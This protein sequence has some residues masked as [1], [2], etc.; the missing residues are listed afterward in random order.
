ML[1]VT[2]LS[3]APP[4]GAT[5]GLSPE[6]ASLQQI[7]NS[8]RFCSSACGPPGTSKTRLPQ[9]SLSS[10]FY[11]LFKD[12]LCFPVQPP[13]FARAALAEAELPGLSMVLPRTQRGSSPTPVPACGVAER[14]VTEG[15]AMQW[16]RHRAR[17][18]PVS[19]PAFSPPGRDSH[20]VGAFSAVY[21]HV[22]GHG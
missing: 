13:N 6:A 18:S 4:A 11:C 8:S 15:G 9:Q 20:A 5:G 19:R 16:G 14:E 7:I 3:P 12:E 17:A 21:W 10:P 1:R 22:R 2:G